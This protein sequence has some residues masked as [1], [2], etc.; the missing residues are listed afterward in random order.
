M[1]V[2]EEALYNVSIPL[3]LIAASTHRA[4]YSYGTSL[5]LMVIGWP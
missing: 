1:D 3:C 2:A 4:S 5:T